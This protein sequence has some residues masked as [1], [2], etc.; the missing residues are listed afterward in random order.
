MTA[1]SSAW[2]RMTKSRT[3]RVAP[4][5]ITVALPGAELNR[6][7]AGVTLLEIIV[8][9]V[10]LG[11]LAV[12]TLPKFNKPKESSI[13]R[14]AIANLKLIQAAQ[15]I[16]KLEMTIYT[17]GSD[18]GELNDR[19]RLALPTGSNAYWDY[20]AETPGDGSAFT[21]KARRT[22]DDNRI[23]YIDQNDDDVSSG[24]VW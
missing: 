12:L 4:G 24:G 1:A 21:A 5:K 10:I 18:A 9:L 3:L 23:K 6:Q 17:S 14:E 11:I 8:V 7:R 22:A 16:Y 15:K 19:L 2:I 13:D 20:K